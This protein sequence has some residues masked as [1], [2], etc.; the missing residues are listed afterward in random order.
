MNELTSKIDVAAQ[1]G[2][3]NNARRDAAEDEHKKVRLVRDEGD[4]TLW[5]GIFL[6]LDAK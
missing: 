4:L 1:T 6:I 3:G 2:R 5:L